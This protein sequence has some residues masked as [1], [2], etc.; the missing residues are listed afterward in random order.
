[1]AWM[2]EDYKKQRLGALFDFVER[3]IGEINDEEFDV[4][5][6]KYGKDVFNAKINQ[7]GEDKSIDNIPHELAEIILK[8]RDESAAKAPPTGGRR[9]RSRRSRKSRKSRKNKS[10]RR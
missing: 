10:S 5:L 1:M 2:N 8:N 7:F 6:K 3:E 9:R 4:A